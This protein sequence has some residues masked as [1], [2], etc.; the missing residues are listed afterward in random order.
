MS[1]VNIINWL[2]IKPHKDIVNSQNESVN[3]LATNIISNNNRMR[4]NFILF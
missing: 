1:H 3:H 2:E 4:F